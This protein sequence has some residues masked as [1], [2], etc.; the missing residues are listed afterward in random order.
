MIDHVLKQA[1]LGNGVTLEARPV[2]E[3]MERKKATKV[4]QERRKLT[5]LLFADDIVL[6]AM[7]VEQLQ[8]ALESM[9]D[10]FEAYG[11]KMNAKKTKW[12]RDNDKSEAKLVVGGNEIERVQQFTYLG[13]VFTENTTDEAD[14][15]ARI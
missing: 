1:K 6:A 14:V 9:N 4:A 13:S 15:K 11:L 5:H 10:A 12:Q 3:Q 2:G 8:Q 7:D